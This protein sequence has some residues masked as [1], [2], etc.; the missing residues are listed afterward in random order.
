MRLRSLKCKRRVTKRLWNVQTARAISLVNSE[1]RRYNSGRVRGS[2][3]LLTGN[4]VGSGVKTTIV[5]ELTIL[6][7]DSALLA[8]TCEDA[9]RVITTLYV[10][11]SSRAKF[12]VG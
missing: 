9:S 6:P 3:K 4:E 12:G 10:A 8:R 5:R 1:R 11:Q 2:T 7:A